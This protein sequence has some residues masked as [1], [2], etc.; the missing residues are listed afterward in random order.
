MTKV[1]IL[2]ANGMLGQELMAAFK[3]QEVS[4]WDRND[5]DITDFNL[6]QEKI[7][8][9]KPEVVINAA[10]YTAVDDCETNRVLAMKVNGEGPGNLAKIC[11]E[12]GAILVHY[13]TDYIFNGQKADGYNE[14]YNQIEPLSVYG[15]SKALGEK[16]IKEN[17]EKYYILRTAWLY[18][19]NG[20]N[21]VDTMIKLGQE[22]PE[23]KVINDQHG[24]P[25]YAKDLALQTRE[26]LLNLQPAFGVYHVTNSGTCTWYEF[27]QEIFKIKNITAKVIP[28]TSQ[29]YPL[30]AKRPTY[31]ILLNTKLPLMRPWQEALKE[32]L[33]IENINP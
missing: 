29:E 31:S 26:I 27:T 22:K 30:P 2:G 33:K 11:K 4:G 15:E 1:L 16:L 24:S 5:I 25:T 18:G 10:A 9:L 21:F 17:C 3:D 32:Y 28:C 19:K 12:I 8:E 14:D 23:L 7:K 20:K 13:S 6:A